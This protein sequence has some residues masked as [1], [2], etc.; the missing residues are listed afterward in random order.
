MRRLLRIHSAS[1]ATHFAAMGSQTWS[2]Q[3]VQPESAHPFAHS[4]AAPRSLRA[5]SCLPCWVAAH[6]CL[7]CLPKVPPQ[8][9]HK[10]PS[11]LHPRR[12][13]LSTLLPIVRTA[14][15]RTRR[16]CCLPDLPQ[17]LPL[18]S[19]SSS[20]AFLSHEVHDP[21]KSHCV[22]L[23]TAALPISSSLLSGLPCRLRPSLLQPPC[24]SPTTT[25]TRLRWP[26]R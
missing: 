21:K 9:T 19:R 8:S 10:P 4:A 6:G 12:L 26:P 17:R 3:N 1:C 25:L 7:A 15:P 23:F 2:P 20:S 14:C 18:C 24:L 13:F 22:S 11:R 16:L 5:Q